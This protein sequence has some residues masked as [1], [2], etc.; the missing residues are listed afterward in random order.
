[1]YEVVVWIICYG[2]GQKYDV[3]A[4]KY[5]RWFMVMSKLAVIDSDIILC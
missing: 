1:M 2:Y 4:Y 3:K 5:E